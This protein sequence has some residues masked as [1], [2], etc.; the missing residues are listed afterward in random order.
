VPD[1]AKRALITGVGGQDGSY[2]S[3]LLLSKGY[4]VF[5][6]TRISINPNL[7]NLSEVIKS[8]N[9]HLLQADMT[10]SE[11]LA[12]AV[13]QSEPDEIYNL[14]AVSYMPASWDCPAHVVNVNAVGPARLLEATRNLCPHAKFYQA[15]TSE[16]FG[17]VTE[18]PQNEL[19]P[20]R[21]V[22][23]YGAAKL[24]AHWTAI[25]FREQYG[26]HVSCG[27][28]FN[29]ESPRRGQQFVTAKVARAAANISLG[30]SEKLSLWTLDSV[31]DWGF[32]GNY[33]EAMWRM[34][35]REKAGDYVIGTG[36]GHS[37]RD[38]VE[39]AFGHLNLDWRD[40][41]VLNPPVGWSVDTR[42]NYIADASRA[43]RELGWKPKVDF[44]QLI[45]M[46]VDADIKRL[47]GIR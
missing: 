33:T 35:Q 6:T 19:T 34:L 44:K 5:G 29:H 24:S 9:F 45:H 8:P 10:D 28:L 31:R 16:M 37:V 38:L 47:R 2:L 22:H 32:A 1:I 42:A 39:C 36:I 43:E 12:R 25:A 26:L 14:A 40:W 17:A 30:S 11:S 23:P 20:F 27:I 15:S 13:R 41:V 18:S 7:Q 46:V 21:P 4:E 3:E